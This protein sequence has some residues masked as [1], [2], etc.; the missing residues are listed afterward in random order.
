M[1][2]MTEIK[3]KKGPLPFE[4]EPTTGKIYHFEKM[5]VGDWFTVDTVSKAE[6]AQNC[7]YAYGVRTG[8]GFRLSRRKHEDVY[9]M[10]RVK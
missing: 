1:A 2:D 6:S 3:I 10:M 4:F 7:A 5:K 9:Y 8:N